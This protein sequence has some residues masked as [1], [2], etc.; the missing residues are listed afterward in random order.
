[1]KKI[2]MTVSFAALFLAGCQQGPN[3][4]K[5][6]LQRYYDDIAETTYEPIEQLVNGEIDVTDEDSLADLEDEFK[7][8]KDDLTDIKE[9]LESNN[10]EKK[11]TNALIKLNDKALDIYKSTDDLEADEYDVA[12][13]MLDFLKSLEDVGDDYFDGE[14]PDTFKEITESLEESEESGSGLEG[15]FGG[16]SDDDYEEDEEYEDDEEYYYSNED[17]AIKGMT[18]TTEDFELTLK[19]A[20]IVPDYDDGDAA[21][22][23]YEVKNLSDSDDLDLD[24]LYYLGTFYQTTDKGHVALDE[25]DPSEEYLE[26]N[27]KDQTLNDNYYL[28]I[29]APGETMQAA[30]AYKLADSKQKIEFEVNPDWDNEPVGTIKMDLATK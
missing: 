24:L 29:V 13:K 30:A 1:M 27:E 4:T 12:I 20:K 23:T 3:Y 7:E 25:S 21:L 5:K 26:S 14:I 15:L 8:A 6:D 28:E 22:I 2:L 16:E 17:V 10:S 11:I 18:I 9:S 19:S